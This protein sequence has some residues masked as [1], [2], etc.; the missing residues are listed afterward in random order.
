MKKKFIDTTD[1]SVRRY[2]KETDKYN[3]ITYQEELELT[4]RISH[5][6]IEAVNDLVTANLNFVISVAKEYQGNGTPLPDLIN[7]GNEG[8]IKAAHKFDHTRGFKFIS[9]AVWWVKQGILQGLND[10]SRGI[11]LPAN[12]INKLHQINKKIGEFENRTGR[13]PFIGE[14]L[15]NNEKPILFEDI[16]YPQIASLSTIINDDGDT[17]E[18]IIPNDNVIDLTDNT[19]TTIKKELENIL[20]KLPS[21]EREII[22]LYFGLKQEYPPMTLEAIGDK[23]N[24][25]KERVRQ[26][27]EKAIRRLRSKS[28]NLHGIMNEQ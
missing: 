9:Y 11:R 16:S 17:L 24:L 18:T 26:V 13:K 20:D 25:T 19:E 22:E 21:R 28:M 5:G 2:L 1:D 23:F 8:M 15:G 7:D 4:R 10:N 6:D 27:K 3:T 12:Q 14:N